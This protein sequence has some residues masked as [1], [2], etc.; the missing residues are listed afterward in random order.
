MYSSYGGGC[1][2]LKYRLEKGSN[3]EAISMMKGGC[4]KTILIMVG[5]WSK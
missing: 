2:K 3:G 4:I 5:M 1:E